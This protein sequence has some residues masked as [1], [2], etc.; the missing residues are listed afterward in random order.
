LDTATRISQISMPKR[1]S[2]SLTKTIRRHS[3]RREAAIRNPEMET[4]VNCVWI[5]GS[6]LRRAPE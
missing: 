6:R 1:S 2:S 5:P 3:G 4:E